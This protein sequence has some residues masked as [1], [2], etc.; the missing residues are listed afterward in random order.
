MSSLYFDLYGNHLR[1]FFT[2]GVLYIVCFAL[3]VFMGLMSSCLTP[4]LLSARFRCQA[5]D[6]R[7]GAI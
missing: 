2:V 6:V 7:A 1:K 3:R 5:E 4:N